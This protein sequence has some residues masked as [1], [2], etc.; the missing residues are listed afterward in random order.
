MGNSGF[1]KL[2]LPGDFVETKYESLYQLKTVD[3]N[4][5]EF[6]LTRQQGKVTLVVNVA[7]Q[8]KDAPG[9]LAALK[10]LHGNLSNKQFEI[11]AFPTNSFGNENTTFQQIK[12]FYVQQQG[13]SFP[14]LAKV[15]I[16]L[17]QVHLS[18]CV[19]G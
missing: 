19:L 13:V 12:E 9:Q 16:N 14:L 17:D 8:T 18:D 5:E 6:D 15:Q 4:K 7:S 1:R 11:L 10:S 2:F 3:I